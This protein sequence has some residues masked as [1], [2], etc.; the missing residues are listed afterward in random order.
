MYVKYTVKCINIHKLL[1]YVYFLYYICIVKIV[2]LMEINEVVRISKGVVFS[3]NQ[4]SDIQLNIL[5][6]CISL[7]NIEYED[8]KEDKLYPISFKRSDIPRVANTITLK[9]EIEGLM[10]LK[11]ENVVPNAVWSKVVPFPKVCEYKNGEINLWLMGDFVKLLVDKK[12]GYSVNHILEGFLLQGGFPKQLFDIFGLYKNR[13]IKRYEVEVNILK[14]K[15]NTDTYKN[16][17][18]QFYDKIIL[19]ALKQINTKTSIQVKSKYART[20][21]HKKAFI[22]FDVYNKAEKTKSLESDV[23]KIKSKGIKENERVQAD[24]ITSCLSKE[25]MISTYGKLEM[26]DDLYRQM[27]RFEKGSA[28]WFKKHTSIS[29]FIQCENHWYALTNNPLTSAEEQQAI[30]EL[31]EN[32]KV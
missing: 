10:D 5:Y 9:T 19:P 25:I 16:R 24:R 6:R 13:N 22:T 20:T 7:L 15:L 31:K 8:V 1:V 26:A 12:E 21:K 4:Y 11:I 27:T 17:P 14:E 18:K 23:P 3:K 28:R 29:K 32:L 2:N 30:K